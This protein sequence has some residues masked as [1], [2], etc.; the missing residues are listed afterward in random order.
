MIFN[1]FA[2]VACCVFISICSFSQTKPPKI[3]FGDIKPEDFAPTVYSI[4]SSADAVYLYDMGSSKHDGNANGWFSVIRTVHER[5]RLLHKKS[6]DDLATI[7]IELFTDPDNTTAKERLVDWQA[8]TYNIEDG[9]VVQTKIDKGSLFKEKDGNYDI[10]KFTFPNLKEGSIIEYTYTTSSP[11]YQDISPWAFQGRYPELWSQFI[12]EEPQFFD[13]VLLKQG[14]LQ[15][16]IDTSILSSNTF[17]VLEP[18]GTGSSEIYSI[19]SNTVK[20]I[21]AF[22]DVPA[23]KDESY[24]TS[25]S[26]YVQK[27]EFQFSAIRFPNEE[28]KTFLTTWNETVDQLMKRDDFGADL[29]KDNGWLKDDV[30]YAIEDET[31]D[32]K[33][34]KKIYSFVQKNIGCTDDRAMYLSQSIKKTNQSKKGNA[35]DINMLL[36]AMLKRAGLV[37]NPVLIS[38]REHGKPYDLYPLL[39]KFNYL[40]SNVEIGDKSYMLDAS[41]DNLGFGHLDEECYNGGARLIASIPAVVYLSADSLRE[42][43]ITTMFL[44]NDEDGKMTGNYKCVMGEMESAETRKKLKKTNQDDYFKDIKSSLSFDASFSNS[45]ID[46]LAQPEM[47][48]SVA[49]NVSFKPDDDIVYFNPL[50]F[51]DIPK[52]NPFK[53]ASRSYP[54]EMPYCMDDTYILNMEVPKGYKVDET[55]KSA[56]VSLNDKEGMFEYLVQHSGNNIQ[57]RCRL[58]LNKANFEPE[59][60]ETLRNFFAFIVEKQS[61]QIVFKKD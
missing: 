39:R 26:N 19:H 43:K 53:A 38:T 61:E 8:A 37:A 27:V 16:T 30:R 32:L 13:F 35:A 12:I 47:P 33:K 1:R 52:E 28:P 7:K 41:N 56:R 55:P 60:Y 59:D 49:Y 50:T 5:I 22:K 15:P 20:H 42:S 21:W 9:K 36:T 4:D 45:E 6:F 3:K 10:E 25:L 17:N 48:V 57:L 29:A 54:V 2:T 23:I 14:Y 24:I 46:S 44:S 51:A 18:G 11:F 31:D 34:A 58:K 40:I